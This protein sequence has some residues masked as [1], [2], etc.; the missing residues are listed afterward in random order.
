MK[1]NKFEGRES[2]GAIRGWEME[3]RKGGRKYVVL[4]DE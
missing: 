3:Q 4:K 1:S 2:G